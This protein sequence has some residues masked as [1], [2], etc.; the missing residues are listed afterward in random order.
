M[1]LSE[2]RAGQGKVDVEVKVKSKQDT[3]VFQ[4][5]GRDLKVANA[6]VED[7]SGEIKMSLWN[8]DADNV[9]VGNTLKITN[10]YVSEFNGEKQ[11]TAGKFGKMEILGSKV[12][13]SATASASK[14]AKSTEKKV[15]SFKNSQA[16]KK[17]EDEAEVDEQILEDETPADDVD[18]EEKE[19]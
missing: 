13:E 12:A 9:Q 10:G 19:F 14:P 3:R 18:F 4:K 15:N 11:L 1:K 6:I 17:T 7:E 5:Y 8:N 16:K 2:L